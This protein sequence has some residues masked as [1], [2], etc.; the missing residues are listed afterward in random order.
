MPA[1]QLG[2]LA[3]ANGDHYV[4]VPK[5]YHQ[6]WFYRKDSPFETWQLSL[7]RN[8]VE[9]RLDESLCRVADVGGGT[10]RFAQ[11]LHSSLGLKQNVL[12]VDLSPDMLSQASQLPGV[13]TLLKDCVEFA[14]ELPEACFDRFL[15]KEVVHHVPPKDLGAFYRGLYTGLRK[16]GVCLTVT[17]PKER[18]EYPFFEQARQVWIR[19]QPEATDF[20][21]AMELAGYKGVTIREHTFPVTLSK[22]LWMDMVSDRFWSTFAR[23]NFDDD[24][25]AAGIQEIDAAFPA[26][27]RGDISFNERMIFIEGYKH[28]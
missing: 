1:L 10:G 2:R 17:R 13:D 16:D 11:L 4:K 8:A 22:Q 6:A 19:D 18:I 12:C 14:A 23:S 25:L 21:T 28:V 26:D 7:I 5:L 24:E 27:E 3:A 15:L 20:A 9:G